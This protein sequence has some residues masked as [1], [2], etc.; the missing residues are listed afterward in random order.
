MF[1]VRKKIKK[2][3]FLRINGGWRGSGNDWRGTEDF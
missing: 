3:W 1:E 2:Q